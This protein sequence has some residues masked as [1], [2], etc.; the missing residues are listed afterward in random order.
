[1]TMLPDTPAE[2]PPEP[3]SRNR[4]VPWE[5][6]RA[7]ERGT[8]WTS[9]AVAAA[10]GILLVIGVAIVGL[11]SS[12]DDGSGTLGAT[13]C[14]LLVAAALLVLMVAPPVFAV[15]CIAVIATAVPIGAAFAVFP[16]A[17]EASEVRAFFAISIIGWLVC[18]LF[19][20]SRGRPV[21]A[22]LILI[23]LFTWAVLEV[24]EWGENSGASIGGVVTTPL[25]GDPFSEDF[26][27]DFEEF[28]DFEDFEDFEGQ[29][30]D[31]EEFEEPEDRTLATGLVA[32]LFAIVYLGALGLL[33][34]ARRRGFAT[35]FVLPGIAALVVAVSLLGS[36]MD[37]ALGGGVLA[38]VAGAVLLY[39]G[40]IARRRF[41]I[42]FGAAMATVGA[43]LIAGDITDPNVDTFDGPPDLVGFG[44]LTAV[45]GAIVVLAA[46]PLRRLLGE[47]EH[48]DEP[49]VTPERALEPP[50]D[51]GAWSRPPDS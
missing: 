40:T 44:V 50:P 42:W 29:F 24:N 16:N 9:H 45:F 18:L 22:S 32:A 26:G 10:G 28:E 37:S 15:A 35:A 41:T 3:P 36:E 19:F 33:D 11:D 23:A 20:G 30:D 31:F 25:G 7:A 34:G 38:I 12:A 46:E 27:G 6:W 51:D 8:P 1:M 49:V 4:I 14:L 47:P 17:D 21:L 13:L 2:N 5:G 43:L 48:G 39:L